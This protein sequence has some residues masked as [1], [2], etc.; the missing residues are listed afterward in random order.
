V[1]ITLLLDIDDT[2][3]INPMDTFIPAYLGAL[4]T[5][6]QVHADANQII[7]QLLF[8]TGQMA[9]NLRP[10]CTL[11]EIFDSF[12]YQALGWEQKEIRPLIN[13]F[14]AE[15]F[16]HLKRL[17]KPR[18]GAIQLVEEALKRDY[19]LAIATN[20]LFPKTAIVQRLAW[21]GL[22]PEDYPFKTIPSYE[23]FHFA[24]PDPAFL[25]ELLAKIG[26]PDQ[27][28]IMIGD[29]I[30][31]DIPAAMELGIPVYWTPVNGHDQISSL[32]LGN[33]QGDVSEFF[34]W[35]DRLDPQE[36]QANYDNPTSLLAILRSTPAALDSLCR[37]VDV[38]TWTHR[39]KSNEWCQTEILCHLRDVETEVN[40]PRVQEV[41]TGMNPFIAGMDTDPWAIE[42]D[43]IAQD[44]PRALQA[45]TNTR[46][47]LLDVLE[48]LQPSDW[49]L[50][51]RHTILGPTNIQELVRIITSHD[52][53]H[54]QQVTSLIEMIS[55]ESPA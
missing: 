5:H 19:Q 48:R 21:A 4:S 40:L 54:I 42:R 31:N 8:A 13:Q 23:T 3:L 15:Q 33:G 12:F 20:P 44:G 35:F 47:K 25:A 43:Y 10:D 16:P 26:W 50:P 29:S 27:P 14:Y 36:L 6:L 53:L 46:I 41:L 7:R 22:S 45:F 39:P 30:D 24:K 34:N 2:L 55:K 17:T 18:P 11:K 37:S 1:T 49:R 9:K 51:A 32:P 28:V 52:R 38:D